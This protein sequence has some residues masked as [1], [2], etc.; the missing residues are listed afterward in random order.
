MELASALE[1]DTLRNKIK[2]GEFTFAIAQSLLPVLGS[3]V[4]ASVPFFGE[5][6]DPGEFFSSLALWDEGR[7]LRGSRQGRM[8]LPVA[9]EDVT[10]LAGSA[11]PTVLRPCYALSVLTKIVLR[12]CYA[13]S[14]TD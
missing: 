14:G 6:S 13:L 7:G 8:L 9:E 1:P 12:P 5:P 10:V 3:K 2:A 11:P 4:E